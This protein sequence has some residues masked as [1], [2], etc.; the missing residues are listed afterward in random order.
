M[1]V[2]GAPDRCP[3][4]LAA[5]KVARFALE[6]VEFVKSML[7][8]EPSQRLASMPGGIDNCK[9]HPF[10]TCFDFAWDKFLSQNMT[11]P[12]K[13]NVNGP[14]DLSNFKQRE[15]ATPK[16]FDLEYRDPGNGWDNDW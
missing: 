2:G 11:P 8:R 15:D 4:P 10:Y 6:A 9:K 12:Y 5:E 3:A 13:P 1:V 16:K 7:N 14:R